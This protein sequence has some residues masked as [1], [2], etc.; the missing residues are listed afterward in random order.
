MDA[1]VAHPVARST[2]AIV[3]ENIVATTATLEDENAVETQEILE[4]ERPMN[5]KIDRIVENVVDTQ[6]ILEVEMPM[7]QEI[8]APEGVRLCVNGYDTMTNGKRV[9]H[10]GIL[11]G[12][13]GRPFNPDETME[14]KK[15]RYSVADLG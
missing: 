3:I 6:N 9:W 15:Q 2:S 1:T 12:C 8:V 5:P 13:R 4:V 11:E 7:N 14:H 10:I